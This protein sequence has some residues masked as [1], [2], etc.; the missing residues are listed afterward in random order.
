MKQKRESQLSSPCCCPHSVPEMRKGCRAAAG[1]VAVE[2]VIKSQWSLGWRLAWEIPG[3]CQKLI[4]FVGAGSCDSECHP[5]WEP[6][7]C[8]THWVFD[9]GILHIS[10]PKCPSPNVQF[11]IFSFIVVWGG[12]VLFSLCEP[13][14]PEHFWF[15]AWPSS[16]QMRKSE[17]AGSGY[18]LVSFLYVASKSL[19]VLPKAGGRRVLANISTTEW[20]L[21]T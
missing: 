4:S 5:E 13:P 7:P 8:T 14:R 18:S 17:G 3:L 16:R 6:Q 10:W 20:L 19:N 1:A 15:K 9:W 21:S 2:D 11:G 12:V